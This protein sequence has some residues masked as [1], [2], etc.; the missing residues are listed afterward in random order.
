MAAPLAFGDYPW[1]CQ[2]AQQR[3]ALHCALLTCRSKASLIRTALD[4]HG[5]LREPAC[6]SAEGD[7]SG[8]ANLH[9]I[10]M[11]AKVD[12]RLD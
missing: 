10:G 1:P 5:L 4:T 6:T 2:R 8:A 3:L 9:K 7:I 12:R 11:L